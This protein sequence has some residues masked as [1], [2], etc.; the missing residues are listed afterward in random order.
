MANC[1][2]S[3]TSI[4]ATHP[5][6]VARKLKHIEEIRGRLTGTPG[7]PLSFALRCTDRLVLDRYSFLVKPMGLLREHGG[8]Q[9]LGK[10]VARNAKA[11]I[12]LRGIC[13]YPE[14][15]RRRQSNAILLY[16]PTDHSGIFKSLVDDFNNRPLRVRGQ[17]W[18]EDLA[19][20]E[21]AAAARD[22]VWSGEAFYICTAESVRLSLEESDVLPSID[23][24][25]CPVH[26]P[27]ML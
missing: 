3:F 16:Y 8:S 20:R 21:R 17:D 7:D 27:P 13:V 11:N 15:G 22:F 26:P 23:E 6:V 2:R 24:L 19:I 18:R 25:E 14:K 5:D 9:R 4:S 12:K 1:C 10:N